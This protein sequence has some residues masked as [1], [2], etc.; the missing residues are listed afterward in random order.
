MAVYLVL[1]KWQS[2]IRGCGSL[3]VTRWC[4]S[5]FVARGY[6]GSMRITVITGNLGITEIGQMNRQLKRQIEY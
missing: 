2:V 1:G 4:S 3:F 5:V 6:A